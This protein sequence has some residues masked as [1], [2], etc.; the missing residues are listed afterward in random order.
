MA[1]TTK[2]KA[3]RKTIQP[4]SAARES[5]RLVAAEA[6]AIRS[7]APAVCN[8]TDPGDVCRQGDVYLTRLGREPRTLRP[9]VGRQLAP[10]TTQG[11]RH[12]VEGRVTML[13]PDEDDAAL[14]LGEAVPAARMRRHFVGPVVLAPAGFTLTHPEHGDRTFPAGAYLTTYQRAFGD[15]IRRALD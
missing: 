12:V 4:A 5:C 8:A 15:E 6:E 14:A 1:M 7:D 3:D 11:S 10:G 9:Y 2:A 13:V